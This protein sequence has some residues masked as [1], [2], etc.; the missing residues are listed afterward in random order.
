[1]E[2]CPVVHIHRVTD[3]GEAPKASG[4]VCP[5]NHGAASSTPKP[6]TPNNSEKTQG[7]D[8]VQVDIDVDS[9]GEIPSVKEYKKLRNVM[10]MI[11][12]FYRDGSAK[13]GENYATM[14][15][16][17]A[18]LDYDKQM[19]EEQLTALEEKPAFKIHPKSK[20]YRKN[21]EEELEGLNKQRERFAKQR[22]DY[23]FLFE[24]S[25]QIVE[26]CEWLELHMDDYCK[27]NVTDLPPNFFKNLKPVPELSEEQK[28]IYR[29][30]L[31]EIT[32]NLD[33]SQD[34]FQA[35]ID[36]RLNKYHNIEKQIIE[37]QL[38]V[39]AK[40]PTDSARREHVAGELEKDLEYVNNNM[41]QNPEAT[42]RR[43][44]MLKNHQ[45]FWKVLKY[46]K[47]KLGALGKDDQD[48]KHYDPKYDHYNDV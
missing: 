37:A 9:I 39:M 23:K 47:D 42:K 16:E 18:K 35:S 2:E 4:G 21:L 36:G 48:I 13:K 34:F 19:V 38:R 10:S 11:T 41:V 3:G 5:V 29:K 28:K 33:E 12:R 22:D 45:E 7:D 20:E 14:V 17:I 44:K 32:Y 24:W 43:E 31:G 26:I 46:H 25:K 15:G 40:Y 30:G 1:M 27:D 6:V 8:V